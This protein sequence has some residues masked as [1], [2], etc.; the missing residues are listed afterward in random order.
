MLSLDEFLV[1]LVGFITAIRA[2]VY[3]NYSRIKNNKNEVNFFTYIN[4]DKN[5][6]YNYFKI[7]PVWGKGSSKLKKFK[8]FVNFLTFSIYFL[9][10]IALVLFI[11]D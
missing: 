11:L 7:K 10:I 8:L 4:S 2:W 5:L 3:Y 1:I 9:F 6:Y